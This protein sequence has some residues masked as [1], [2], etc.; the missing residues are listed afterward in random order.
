MSAFAE[1]MYC[2]TA[3][4]AAAT[5]ALRA[6]GRAPVACRAAKQPGASAPTPAWSEKATVAGGGYGGACNI[7][8][9]KQV[10]EECS[11]LDGERQKA[12]WASSGAWVRT[13]QHPHLGD[14]R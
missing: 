9:V 14:P 1:T 2:A 5:C 8:T 11:T 3:F 10:L 4:P 7:D 6:R 13:T 12:C